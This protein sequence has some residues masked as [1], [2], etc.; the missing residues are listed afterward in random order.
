MAALNWEGWLTIA[1]GVATLAMLLWERFT[2]DKVLIGAAAVLMASG[3]L[4][5]K[6]AL[7]GFWNPGVVTVA[8]LFV[9]VAAL[10]STR[11]IRWNG[12]GIPGRQNGAWPD[13]HQR[14]GI[15]GTHP[16]FTTQPPNKAIHNA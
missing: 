7:A 9:C 3:V 14:V 6:E 1:V 16:A 15:D 4:A 5:P 8:V 11:A 12:D 13:Q 10:K 2:P